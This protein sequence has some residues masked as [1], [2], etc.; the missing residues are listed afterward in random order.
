MAG[1]ASVLPA[2][3]GPQE[4]E[5]GR[6]W[7]PV[8][9]FGLGAVVWPAVARL[10]LGMVVLQSE[11]SSRYRCSN[12]PYRNIILLSSQSG[13]NLPK[14]V[15]VSMVY[16]RIEGIAGNNDFGR[17]GGRQYGCR[18]KCSNSLGRSTARWRAAR[19]GERLE[20]MFG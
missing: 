15:F 9:D 17:R 19:T 7:P 10:G 13:Q 18:C 3:T 11:P 5:G 1:A 12:S 16:G 4:S 20:G 14:T 8:G 6:W 2:A